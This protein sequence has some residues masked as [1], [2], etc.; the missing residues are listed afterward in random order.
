MRELA[1]RILSGLLLLL[2]GSEACCTPPRV[3]LTVLAPPREDAGPG[4]EAPDAQT[5]DT[6][7]RVCLSPDT[8]A[9][10]PP[11]PPGDG[12]EAPA[13]RQRAL[14]GLADRFPDDVKA[15]LGLSPQDDEPKKP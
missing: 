10:W 15:R 14:A 4:P 11:S 6:I 9:L 13:D 3:C 12:P 1:R 8:D 5:P 2:G 7:F